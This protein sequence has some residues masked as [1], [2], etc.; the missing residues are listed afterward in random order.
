MADAMGIPV[1]ERFPQLKESLIRYAS[2]VTKVRAYDK[3]LIPPNVG[4]I[5]FLCR[6]WISDQR[7]AEL[8]KAGFNGAETISELENILARDKH[9]RECCSDFRL[10]AQHFDSKFISVAAYVIEF[11]GEKWNK[12]LDGLFSE[13]SRI[14]YEQGCFKKIALAH[15]F[16]FD[17]EENRLEFDGFNVEKLDDATISRIVG[18][19]SNPAFLHPPNVGDFF[20]ISGGPGP[21]DDV[22]SWLNQK[23]AEGSSFTQV[24]QYFK[25]GIVHIDYVVPHYSPIWVNEIRKRGIFFIGN[26]RRIAYENGTKPYR[27][28]HEEGEEIQ[29]WWRA[30]LT[31]RVSERLDDKRN[32]LRQAIYRAGEYYELN[33]TQV[34]P[35]DRLINLAISF[36][37]LFSPADH[38]ELSFRMSQ[39][40]S[41]L[42][43]TSPD[44][45]KNIF[46]AMRE[47]YSRRSALLHGSYDVAKYDQGRFVSHAE[48]DSWSAIIRDAVAR[49]IALY[50]KGENSRD[51]ILAKLLNGALDTKEAE[52]LRLASNLPAFLRELIP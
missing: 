16:N 32:Q 27:L 18:E 5:S 29:S 25:D 13:F 37:A 39:C 19:T 3:Q 43:G 1:E 14:T 21:C 51:A 44:E 6:S 45:R 50:L 28:S 38:G 9:L 10:L 2:L 20:V 12:V 4:Q 42:V 48:C 31:S 41:Q 52:D 8:L 17:A 49:F 30:R 15:L 46:N 34:H 33:H 22:V 7:Q 47:M 23:Y 11:A 40:I 35:E 36:E 26:P 24:L